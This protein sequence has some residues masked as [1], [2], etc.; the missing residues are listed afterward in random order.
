MSREQ[1]ERKIEAYAG[2]K[3]CMDGKEGASLRT[4]GQEMGYLPP[5]RQRDRPTTRLGSSLWFQLQA[6][7]QAPEP[8]FMKIETEARKCPVDLPW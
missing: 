2:A 5:T 1:Q 6:N 7:G 8:L 4:P 3:I